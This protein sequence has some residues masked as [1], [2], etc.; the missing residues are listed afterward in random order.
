MTASRI[1]DC[2]CSKQCRAKHLQ[3]ELMF[4]EANRFSSILTNVS[5]AF[6]LPNRLVLWQLGKQQCGHRKEAINQYIIT[7]HHKIEVDLLCLRT[8]VPVNGMSY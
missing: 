3:A 4:T 2:I 8:H 1:P 7:R 6:P 5:D